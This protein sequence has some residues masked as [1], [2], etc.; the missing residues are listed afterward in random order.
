M[1]PKTHILIIKP[2]YYDLRPVWAAGS[3]LKFG[4]K[5]CDCRGLGPGC[6]GLRSRVLRKGLKNVVGFRGVWGSARI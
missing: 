6:H 5:G 4:V 2:L 1:G 3:G